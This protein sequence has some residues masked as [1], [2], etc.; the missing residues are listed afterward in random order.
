MGAPRGVP[1][2]GANSRPPVQQRPCSD[3][4]RPGFDAVLEALKDFEQV[5]NMT[6]CELQRGYWGSLSE[7]AG[8]S[9]SVW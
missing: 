1:P 9:S 5:R 7:E 4:G 2:V 8:R 3:Y 6:K